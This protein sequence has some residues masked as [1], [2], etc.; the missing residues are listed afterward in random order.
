M[1]GVHA[2][3]HVYVRVRVHACSVQTVIIY[4]AAIYIG[5]CA[6]DQVNTTYSS[7][8]NTETASRMQERSKHPCPKVCR[9]WQ[10]VG[11]E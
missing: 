7:V 1:Y 9:A 11:L 6:V 2:C 3:I 10:A 5:V 4:Y 8:R